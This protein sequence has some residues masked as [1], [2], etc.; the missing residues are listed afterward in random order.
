MHVFVN[1]VLNIFYQINHYL[2]KRYFQVY[3]IPLTGNVENLY[4]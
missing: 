1:L 2:A 4:N 3:G